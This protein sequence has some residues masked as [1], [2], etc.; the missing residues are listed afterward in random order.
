MA[1]GLGLSDVKRQAMWLGAP[2][3]DGGGVPAIFLPGAG[4]DDGAVCLSDPEETG[5]SEADIDALDLL[6]VPRSGSD[7]DLSSVSAGINHLSLRKQTSYRRV[8]DLVFFT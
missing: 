3:G 1:N 6:K 5:H 4:E 8:P 7:D 2:P